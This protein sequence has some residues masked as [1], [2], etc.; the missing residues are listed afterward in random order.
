MTLKTVTD[1]VKQLGF[2]GTHQQ[3]WELMDFFDTYVQLQ[4]FSGSAK[5]KPKFRTFQDPWEAWL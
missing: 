3:N 1:S 2:S 5:W 4:D